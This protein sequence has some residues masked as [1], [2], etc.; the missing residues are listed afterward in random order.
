MEAASIYL[1]KQGSRVRSSSR[2]TSATPGPFSKVA[3]IPRIREF[4]AARHPSWVHRRADC[5]AEPPGEQPYAAEPSIGKIMVRPSIP[6]LNFC[7]SA[8]WMVY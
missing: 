4:L 6:P 2:A 1:S 5:S 3:S 7:V 8:Q